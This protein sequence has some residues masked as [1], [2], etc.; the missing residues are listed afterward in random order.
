M[1]ISVAYSVGNIRSGKYLQKVIFY[2]EKYE[3][4]EIPEVKYVDY[5]NYTNKT[6]IQLVFDEV[7]NKKDIQREDFYLKYEK[8]FNRIRYIS[9][10]NI[11]MKVKLIGTLEFEMLYYI[12]DKSESYIRNIKISKILK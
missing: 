7:Y 9:H 2:N 6:H 5:I 10:N 1:G 11:L 4:L 3:E 8:L 12:S